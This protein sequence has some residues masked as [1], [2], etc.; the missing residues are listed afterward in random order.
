M[1]TLKIVE[2]TWEDAA[3]TKTWDE[4]DPIPTTYIARTVGFLIER[5]EKQ[6]VVGQ[7]VFEEDGHWR[8]ISAIPARMIKR[9]RVLR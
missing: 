2:V 9:V 4:G 1:S 6:I 8:C 7:E 3:L 5:N